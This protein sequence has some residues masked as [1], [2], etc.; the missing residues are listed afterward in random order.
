MNGM[1]TDTNISR[2]S[3]PEVNS[4]EEV[5]QIPQTSLIWAIPLDAV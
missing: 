5:L 1:I 2:K 4:N 3:E